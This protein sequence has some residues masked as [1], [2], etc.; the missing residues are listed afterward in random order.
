VEEGGTC[1]GGGRRLFLWWRKDALASTRGGEAI[2]VFLGAA[3]QGVSAPRHQV[4]PLRSVA[5]YIPSAESTF[6]LRVRV[7][8]GDGLAVRGGGKD[9]N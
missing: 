5:S 9:L 6:R 4:A 7:Y 2:L 1:L 3:Q 8:R